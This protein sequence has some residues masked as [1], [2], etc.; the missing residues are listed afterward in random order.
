MSKF[1][2]HTQ[3]LILT[4]LTVVTLLGTGTARGALAPDNE[5]RP[6]P[7]LVPLLDGGTTDVQPLIGDTALRNL[8]PSHVTEALS[9]GLWNSACAGATIMLAKQQ[10]VMDALGVFAM[11]AALRNDTKAL[12]SAMKRLEQAEFPPRY[13]EQ[14]TQGILLLR[15]KSPDKAGAIFR[16]VLGQRT[17]DPLALYFEGEALHAQGKDTEAIASF[18]SSLK[19]WPDHAPAHS[20]VARLTTTGNASKSALQSA[21]ASTERA[22]KIDPTNRAYWQQLAD[23]CDRAGETGRASAI[24]LQWLT[25]RSP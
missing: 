25:R 1:A 19:G 23:L 17:D 6:A 21:I 4:V 11:C 9:K 2:Y 14:L 10:P 20:A 12:H 15:K 24:R 7:T 22:T 18:K 13:Y 3:Q 8:A 16:N 5:K